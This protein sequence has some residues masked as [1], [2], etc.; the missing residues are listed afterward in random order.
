MINNSPSKK[1][2]VSYPNG[3]YLG[4]IK[5]DSGF[6]KNR[7]AFRMSG[8]QRKLIHSKKKATD[9][10]PDPMEDANKIFSRHGFDENSIH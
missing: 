9:T 4:V 5:L 3:R 2:L 8:C 6:N 1:Y 10:T 7:E